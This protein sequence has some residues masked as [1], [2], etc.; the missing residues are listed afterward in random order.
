VNPLGHN[1]DTI[2]KN[3]FDGSKVVGREVNTEKTKDI[4][5]SRHWNARHNHDRKIANRSFENVWKYIGINVLCTLK[6]K[7]Y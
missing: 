6:L 2:K 7:I 5:L 4:L 3:N 1:I